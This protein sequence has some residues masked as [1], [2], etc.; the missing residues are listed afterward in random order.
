MRIKTILLALL[1]S[2]SPAAAHAQDSIA[3]VEHT[4]LGGKVAVMAPA[5]FTRMT[6]EAMR[7]KYPAQRPPTEALTNE[8][9]SINVAFNHTQSAMTPAQIPEAFAAVER[10][11]KATYPGSRWNRSEV[12]RQG[13]RVF[14][15]LDFWSPALDTEVRNIMVVTSV[16][17]RALIV[18]FNVTRQLEGEWGPVGER[19]MNSIRVIP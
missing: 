9:G 15:V 6:A 17:G 8:S 2:V 19:M 13:G 4:A 18:S 16:D 11:I 12:V 14:G 7:A 5:G 1:L 10:Q 3:L